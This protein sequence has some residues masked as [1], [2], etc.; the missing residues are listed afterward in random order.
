MKV[1]YAPPPPVVV[2]KGD[3]IITLTYEEAQDIVSGIGNWGY[4]MFTKHDV[5]DP[6]VSPGNNIQYIR[7]V[8]QR[9]SQALYSSI[10]KATDIRPKYQP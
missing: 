9:M 8:G 4:D 6:Y 10:I 2:P 7:E 3:I 5:S 1:S